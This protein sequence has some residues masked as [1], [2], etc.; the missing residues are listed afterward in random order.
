MSSYTYPEARTVRVTGLSAEPVPFLGL[1]A[2]QEGRS[3]RTITRTEA[4]R[5]FLAILGDGLVGDVPVSVIGVERD[6]NDSENILVSVVG[7]SRVDE[8]TSSA[9]L[10]LTGASLPIGARVVSARRTDP[11]VLVQIDIDAVTK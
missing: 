10:S 8:L 1:R 11:M 5:G 9:G 2:V 6:P 7:G 4:I 3:P